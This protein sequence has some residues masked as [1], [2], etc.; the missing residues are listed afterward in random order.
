[1]STTVVTAGQKMERMIRD[2]PGGLRSQ[3][4]VK[5]V[6]QRKAP[7]F[8]VSRKGKNYFHNDFTIVVWVCYELI[9]ALPCQTWTP[10]GNSY[11]DRDSL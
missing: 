7:S 2:H 10:S 8:K 9:R 1:M 11:P 5:E 3:L 4:H 6:Q